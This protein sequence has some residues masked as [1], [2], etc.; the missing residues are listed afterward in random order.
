MVREKTP[1]SSISIDI[2][3]LQLLSEVSVLELFQSSLISWVPLVRVLVFYWQSQSFINISSKSQKKKKRVQTHS[4]SERSHT[5]NFMPYE[6]TCTV[7]YFSRQ[8]FMQKE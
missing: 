4:F 2:F 8:F 5:K 1:W 7:R 3:Q 6:N